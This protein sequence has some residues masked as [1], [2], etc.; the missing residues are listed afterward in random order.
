MK[1]L[2]L[3]RQFRLWTVLLV[4]VPSLLIMGIY[5]VSQI[6]VAKQQKLELIGQR[7]H[8]QE[9]LI[10]YWMMERAQNIR[11]I[12]QSEV[13]RTLDEQRM[14][15]A[16]YVKQQAD[17]NFDSLSYINKDGFL[18]ITT[19]GVGIQYPSAVDK[20]YFEAALAGKEYISDV[21]IGRNSGLAII[22]FSCPIYD[23]AGN[24][25]GAI[26]GSISTATLEILLR[27]SWIGQ[28]GE[29]FLVNREGTMLTE[30]RHVNILIDKGLVK[31]TAKM[32]FKITKNAFRNI[33]LGQS[34]TAE[35]IDYRGNKVLGAYL[36]MPEHSWTFIG[37]I[38]EMEVLSPIYQQLSMMAVG[39]FILVLLILPLATQITNKIKQPIDWLIGQSNLIAAEEYQM[40]GRDNSLEKMPHELRDLCK[41]FVQM[42][43]KIGDTVSLLKENEAKL[44]NEVNRQTW[45]LRQSEGRIRTILNQCPIGIIVIDRQGTIEAVNQG[46]ICLLPG[47]TW[48]DVIG[49]SYMDVV[50]KIGRKEDT[51]IYKALQGKAT[52]NQHLFVAD[53]EWNVSVTPIYD[54]EHITG[55]VGVYLDITD[56]KQK[57]RERIQALTRFEVLFQNNLAAMAVVNLPDQV[58]VDVNLA[59][60][61]LTGFSRDI[62]IG[63]NVTELGIVNQNSSNNQTLWQELQMKGFAS[64]EYDLRTKNGEDKKTICSMIILDDEQEQQYLATYIDVTDQRRMEAEIAQFDRLNVVGEM[65]VGI[66]HEIRNPMTTV[67][68][69]LQLFQRKAEFL[70]YHEQINIM[71][72]ELDRA[73]N[74]ITE[75]L[76]LAKDKAVEMKCGNLNH[77]IYGLYPLIQSDALRRGH[78]IQLEIGN[79]PDTIFDEKDIRH[80]ILN[81]VR[82]GLEA[83]EEQG[84]VIIRTFLEN[85]QIIL[86][87]QDTGSGI[88]A[89]ILAKLGTPFM[90]TK[91]GATGLGLPVC[92]RVADRNRGKISVDTGKMGT[93]FAVKFSS[94]EYDTKKSSNN[95]QMVANVN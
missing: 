53:R 52:V 49:H 54:D 33:Q 41:I 90:T 87:V 28:T 58:C 76:S 27:E 9:R 94:P 74:I 79:I 55:A 61:R 89:E 11:E 72:E 59:W 12:S 39:T 71:I 66:G 21:V 85:H 50:D 45:E 88:S 30:P 2:P 32:K 15:R 80:L 38:D 3:Q 44:E 77:V 10:G 82:N 23:Y 7:V 81:L 83:M 18:K 17:S 25:Q 47:Y 8:S 14:K 60:E 24:F 6:S 63:R 40:V 93:T 16:L 43:G 70:K 31:D 35:W 48:I 62:V 26:L 95:E 22:N 34:G 69:Y 68:G 56:T 86:A 92:F 51:L 5:T 67:G 19:L 4:I 91:D 20:P 64:G 57:E 29:V 13:F 84:V 1:N 65:A 46:F 42:S 37:K 78:N 75:F 36:D 73:N